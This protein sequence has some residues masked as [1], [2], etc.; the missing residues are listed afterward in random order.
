MSREEKATM[1]RTWLEDGGQLRAE[2]RAVLVEQF[3]EVARV[4]E[5]AGQRRVTAGDMGADGGGDETK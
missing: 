3:G 1:L 2:E 4:G 5:A